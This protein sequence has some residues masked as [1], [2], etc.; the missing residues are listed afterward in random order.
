LTFND[1]STVSFCTWNKCQNGT[2]L[3]QGMVET[4]QEASSHQS[5]ACFFRYDHST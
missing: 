4:S 3:N 5:H 1:V 2:C